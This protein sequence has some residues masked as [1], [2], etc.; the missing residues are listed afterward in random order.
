M[1]IVLT[2]SPVGD[3]FRNR[4][5]QF[6]SIINCCTIDW[7]NAWPPEALYSVAR[8]QFEEFEEKLGIKEVL[9]TLSKASMHIHQSV[10]DASEDFYAELR[11]RNY[12]TPTSYLDLI[13]TYVELLGK[14]RVIVPAKMTRYQNGITRLAETNI[15]VDELK[16]K[17]IDLMPVIET[18][19]KDTQEMVVDLEK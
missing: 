18:K 6:P 4:C 14:Q 15:M 16:K 12:T 3:Q 2:F 17:L 19:S 5:R 9:D 11:R 8:R 1:H 13:K 10:K 7:Y